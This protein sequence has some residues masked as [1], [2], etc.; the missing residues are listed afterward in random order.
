MS[1][2]AL[3]KR[4]GVPRWVWAIY[5]VLVAIVVILLIWRMTLILF[6]PQSPLAPPGQISFSEKDDLQ[7]CHQSLQELS[8][9]LLQHLLV[10]EQASRTRDE[11]GLAR[12]EEDSQ[13]WRADAER[14]AAYCRLTE[15][16]ETLPPPVQHLA[17]AYQSLLEMEALLG[18]TYTS[19]SKQEE[20]LF[21]RVKTSLSQA[22]ESL[23]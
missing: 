2:S 22:K 16:M 14:V 8:E 17:T 6:L 12:W 23:R 10:L 5:F 7:G 15:P 3:S 1:N 4:R 11:V 13:R 19:A 21:A 18:E 20:A 9:E